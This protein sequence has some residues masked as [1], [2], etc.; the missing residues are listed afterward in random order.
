MDKIT[1]RER[2]LRMFD[3]KE[4]DRIPVTDGPW[5]S[6]IE[7]WHREGL[8]ENC[9][10]VDYFGLDN[11]SDISVNNGPRYP[12]EVLYETDEHKIHTNSW[13]VKMKTWKH[14]GGT[15]EFLD[16][17]IVDRP[18]W[19]KA[20]ERM[21]PADDRVNLSGTE[22]CLMAMVDDPEWLMDI[23]NAQID[24][25]LTMLDRVLDAGY[26]L[27]AI[28][29]CDDMGYK[30]NQF[31]SVNTY[32]N[33]LKPFHKRAVDWAHARG[34]KARLHS[35]GDVNPFIPD[36]IDIGIDGLN[37]MEV[38]AGMDPVKLKKTYGDKLLLHGGINAQLYNEPEKLE[39]EM[40]K[41]IPALKESGGYIFSS[42]HS[43][44]DSVSLKNFQQIVN[45]AKELGKYD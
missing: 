28:F 37:P 10:Y 24:L 41:I 34:L 8:P 12:V 27:D 44:P 13:G 9:S 45:F 23:Y 31:F 17:T 35:C 29:W 1:C 2:F 22:R 5:S 19:Q 21:L 11:I 30:G 26:K 38:K 3:H 33:L 16:F 42:D 20:K 32:R 18:S 36:L 14:H 40:R 15:P 7:R 4:A 6:T 43:V 25:N 39:E